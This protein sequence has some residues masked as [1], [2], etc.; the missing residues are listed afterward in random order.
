MRQPRLKADARPAG[1]H[2]GSRITNGQHLC[3]TRGPGAQEAAYFVGLL[4]G[5]PPSAASRS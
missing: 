3:A 4:P 2:C 1:Y 5:W